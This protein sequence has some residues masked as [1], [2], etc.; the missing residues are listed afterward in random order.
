VQFDDFVQTIVDSEGADWVRID[1]PV[2][3]QS[4]DWGRFG[5]SAND[6]VVGLSE[7]SQLATLRTDLSISIAR[8]LERGASFREPWTDRFPDTHATSG[9]VD[10][11]WNGRTVYRT[12]EVHVDGG[13]ASLPIPNLE[14]LGVPKRQYILFQLL[15][16]LFGSGEFENYFRMAGFSIVESPWPR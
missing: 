5:G 6:E 11:L 14:G 15:D 7:H 4:L 2:F 3:L 13:R 16:E 9:Y 1:R 8:G 12:A 10:L